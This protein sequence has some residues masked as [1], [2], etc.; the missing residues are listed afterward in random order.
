M[1][2]SA[3]YHLA[4][5]GAEV[6]VVDRSDQG[7]ATAAGAG[8]LFPWVMPGAPPATAALGKAAVEHYPR[9]I[10]EL[11]AAGVDDPG[12]ARVGSVLVTEDRAALDVV[13]A[14][15]VEISRQPGMSGLGEI[16]LLAPGEPAARFP[17]LRPDLAGV[18]AEG[19]GRVDGRV[20][21]D[22]LEWVATQRGAR[23]R[24]GS[25]ALLI[26]G[27]RVTGAIV[28]DETISADAVV[29][30][31]GAWSSLLCEPVGMTVPV[32]PQRGQIVHLAL[33][34]RDT[35]AWPVVQTL[36]DHYLLAFPGGRVVA[37]AT[38]ESDSGFDFRVTAKGLRRV[39]GD[40]LSVAPGLSEGTVAE[41]RVGFRPFSPDGIP[42]IGGSDRVSGLVVATGL[43]PIGLTLGP[44]VGAAAADLALGRTVHL[45][46]EP[47]RPDRPDTTP[48]VS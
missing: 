38:R 12:Y 41:V 42:T 6:V 22:A 32:F 35:G 43:G 47:Y 24:P 45:D 5:A 27:S 46:L 2:A 13:H 29:V 3:A 40:A 8:I 39:L 48:A 44:Y 37:G 15:L 20:F 31:A 18:W 17:P 26:D 16:E 1:G 34:G 21:R 9:L 10:D 28:D 19:T 23:R 33:P 7:Q 30:A 36:S 11:V 14:G 25:A 4:T